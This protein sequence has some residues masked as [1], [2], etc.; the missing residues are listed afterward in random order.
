MG[1]WVDKRGFVALAD[2]GGLGTPRG[3]ALLEEEAEEEEGLV[4]V[5]AGEG[6]EAEAETTGIFRP[7]VSRSSKPLAAPPPLL[8]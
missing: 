2:G 8:G 4:L 1:V 3:C 7:P 6:E 5:V